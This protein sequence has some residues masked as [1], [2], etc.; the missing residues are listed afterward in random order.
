M[1][2]EQTA[3]LCQIDLSLSAAGEP[4]QKQLALNRQGVYVLGKM[5][6]S[7]EVEDCVNAWCLG[8]ASWHR[9][10]HKKL[11]L[12]LTNERDLPTVTAMALPAF[13]Q[14]SNCCVLTQSDGLRQAPNRL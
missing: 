4:N 14:R 7:N 12:A 11:G 10:E 6:G 8:V 13:S 1:T 2:G 3:D 9:L 5:A